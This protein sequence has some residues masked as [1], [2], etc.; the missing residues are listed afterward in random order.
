MKKILV[1]GGCGFIGS[2]FV[3]DQVKKNNLVINL[4]KMTYAANEDNI[5]DVSANE[6]YQF[7][8]GDIGDRKLI[9]ELLEKYQIDWLVNFAAESHVDNSISGPEVFITTNVN[10]VFSLLDASLKYWKNLSKEKQD[11]FRFLHVST[12]E[13]YGSLKR[14]DPKFNENN[15]YKPNSPYSASKAA[16]D[17]LVRAWNETYGLPTLT[18]NCSNNFGPRQHTEKLIPTVISSCLAGKE[19]PIY[20][21][22][23]NIRD[24]IYVEDH[25]NGIEL[26]LQKGQI[27][28]TY[29][30]GGNAERENIQVVKTICDILDQVQPRIDGKSYQEQISFVT[31]RLGHDARY[32]ID[33]D[34]ARGELGFVTKEKFETRI[35]DTVEWYLSEWK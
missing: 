4:D 10:G 31:D 21:K 14:S 6:N 20:G 35:R 29:C 30:F 11:E 7:I 32:A 28:Q 12:D 8:K 22:G 18:T 2:C 1:T 26:A 27:G 5:S 9:S 3:I 16:S 34:K 24:W 25:C 23:D 17:H 15:P 19:I 33:D 13:V